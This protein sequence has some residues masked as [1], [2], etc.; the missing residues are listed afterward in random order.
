VPSRA[1]STASSP[2]PSIKLRTT[3]AGTTGTDS[4][5]LFP[6]PEQTNAATKIQSFYRSRKA[7]ATVSQ[8]GAKFGDLKRAFT[9][10]E[11][12]DYLSADGDVI[13]LKVDNTSSPSHSETASESTSS[14]RLAFTST[15]VP[16]RAYDEDL[17]RILTKLD[18]VESWGGRNVRERRRDVVR[19]VELE[20][21]RIE[22]I[23]VETWRR[24]V[25][26]AEDEEV[27][28]ALVD[29][30]EVL[31]SPVDGESAEMTVD[32]PWTPVPVDH[33]SSAVEPVIS[34]SSDGSAEDTFALVPSTS[35]SPT[36][37]I[38]TVPFPLDSAP[39]EEVELGFSE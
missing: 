17:N 8:L 11:A 23:W 37:K 1:H 30:P 39:V 5:P 21:A 27:S 25:E 13:T 6:T 28:A 26:K 2:N 34:M 24:F 15:N 12:I 36:K 18:A 22:S 20:A 7:L 33:L 32:V 4:Q 31:P 14:A 38:S 16:I 29:G 35:S 9:L 19:K 10:P 3:Q